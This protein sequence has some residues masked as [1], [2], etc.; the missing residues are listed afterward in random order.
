MR[1][2][3][4]RRGRVWDWRCRRCLHETD[5]NTHRCISSSS[6]SSFSSQETTLINTLGRFSFC[7]LSQGLN[8][9][10]PFIV[11]VVVVVVVVLISLAK[12]SPSN[13]FQLFLYSTRRRPTNDGV[14][15]RS[16]LCLAPFRLPCW[17][18][19]LWINK[20]QPQLAPWLICS[21]S[22]IEPAESSGAAAAR[23]K[24]IQHFV[25]FVYVFVCLIFLDVCWLAGWQWDANWAPIWLYRRARWLSS[26]FLS[27]Y[28]FQQQRQRQHLR[29]QT[30]N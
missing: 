17:L 13:Q 26:S 4:R 10:G 18:S 2:L 15:F 23:A 7:A 22:L 6:S 3:A 1:S 27:L 30:N 9:G 12:L 14:I 29:H 20:K 19:K 25:Q 5:K 11:V 21:S 28:C 8:V 24:A 16:N